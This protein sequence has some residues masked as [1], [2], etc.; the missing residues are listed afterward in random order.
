MDDLNVVFEKIEIDILKNIS[1]HFHINLKM[2]SNTYKI[3]NNG[4][5][6]IVI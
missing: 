1:I 2:D 6:F 4:Q 5:I 3:Q